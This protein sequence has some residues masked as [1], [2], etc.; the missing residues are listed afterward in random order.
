MMLECGTTYLVPSVVVTLEAGWNCWHSDLGTDWSKQSWTF[1]LGIGII[2]ATNRIVEEIAHSLLVGDSG[3]SG[4]LGIDVLGRE[5]DNV[6][7][8][9]KFENQMLSIDNKGNL[10]HPPL[11]LRIFLP[12]P[13]P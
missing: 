4:P 9:R 5:P 7:N 1:N 10:P 8:E 3:L 11:S 6:V 2:Q 12:L 13:A